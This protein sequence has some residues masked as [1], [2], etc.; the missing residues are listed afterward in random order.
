M[1]GC[2]IISRFFAFISLSLSFVLAGCASMHSALT[3]DEKSRI[4]LFADNLTSESIGIDG[5]RYQFLE[6]GI[7]NI[8]E[9]LLQK[10]RWAFQI[11]EQQLSRL[12]DKSIL[13]KGKRLREI[14]YENYNEDFVELSTEY[15]Y[16]ANERAEKRYG[17]KK[18]FSSFKVRESENFIFIFDPRLSDSTIDFLSIESEIVLNK[19]TSLIDPDSNSV[20]N[21]NRLSVYNGWL[22]GNIEANSGL[23]ISTNGKIPLIFTMTQSEMYDIVGNQQHAEYGG[24]TMFSPLLQ[25]DSIKLVSRVVINYSNPLSVVALSHEIAHAFAFVVFSRPQILEELVSIHQPKK[26]QDLGFSLII[27]SMPRLSAV[28]FEGFGQWSGWHNSVFYE[29]GILPSVHEL[30]LDRSKELPPLKSLLS[31]D[32][33]ISFWDIIKKIFGS[34]PTTKIAT[35]FVGSASFIDYLI[36]NS[37]PEQIYLT[38]SGGKDDLT[39]SDLELI[40]KRS[41]SQIESDWRNYVRNFKR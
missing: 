30:L 5:L 9:F 22:S 40:Y 24:H 32:I 15:Y 14:I 11:I 31:G 29:A 7:R 38:F 20:L 16:W 39:E 36:Y 27:P 12:Q 37:T 19:L 18:D 13:E 26:I 23:L 28:T 41:F 33:D 3:V 34:N 35:Y 25:N 2:S 10:D 8:G 1:S 21:F 6:R 17:I 4:D